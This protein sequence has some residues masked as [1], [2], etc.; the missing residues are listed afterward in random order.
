MCENY[1]T[2]EDKIKFRIPFRRMADTPIKKRGGNG[3]LFGKIRPFCS[4]A[5]PF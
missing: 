4:T 3:M 2:V 1:S 5:L